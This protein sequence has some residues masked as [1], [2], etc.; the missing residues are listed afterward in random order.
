MVQFCDSAEAV[1]GVFGVSRNDR[2]RPD[3]RIDLG[4]FSAAW[5]DPGQREYTAKV[6]R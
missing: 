3:R 2:R 6:K 5:A 1:Y 4:E